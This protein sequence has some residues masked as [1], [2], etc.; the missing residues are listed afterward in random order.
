M[1]YLGELKRSTTFDYDVN[2]DD[3]ISWTVYMFTKQFLLFEFESKIY[4]VRRIRHELF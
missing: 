4:S 2:V 1:N 3:F